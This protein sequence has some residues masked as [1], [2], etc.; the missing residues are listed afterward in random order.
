[1]VA[2]HITSP[3]WSRCLRRRSRPHLHLHLHPGKFGPPWAAVAA[4]SPI[5]DPRAVVAGLVAV[6]KTLPWRRTATYGT[7]AVLLG[8]VLLMLAAPQDLPGLTIPS[9]HMS[10]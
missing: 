10:M 7:A 2:R 5:G 4:S 3:L 6:E 9:T 1:M 8:L